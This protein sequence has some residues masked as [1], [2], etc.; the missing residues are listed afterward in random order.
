MILLAF[1]LVVLG[2]GG[3]D[4][5]YSTV[6]GTREDCPGRQDYFVTAATMATAINTATA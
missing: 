1:V 5:L 3:Y 6:S 4:T 2:G